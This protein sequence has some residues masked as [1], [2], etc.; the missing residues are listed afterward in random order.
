MGP[1]AAGAAATPRP[2]PGGSAHFSLE[3]A[4][5]G[6]PPVHTA[7]ASPPTSPPPRPPQQHPRAGRPVRARHWPK[8]APPTA[9]GLRAAPR[10]GGV[11]AAA[12]VARRARRGAPA[13]SSS[14]RPRLGVMA[15]HVGGG[16][17]QR[18]RS[19][20][21][22]GWVA[23]W[24]DRRAAPAGA[25]T[26]KW[27]AHTHRTGGEL[28]EGGSDVVL[29][30][31]PWRNICDADSRPPCRWRRWQRAATSGGPHPAGRPAATTRV[32]SGRGPR[33]DRA[34]DDRGRRRHA[35]PGFSDHTPPNPP[36][37]AAPPR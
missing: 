20:R 31:L 16:G 15:R 10:A 19:R 36:P 35:Q 33:S 34:A 26:V 23:G 22:G 2:P 28:G 14:K 8:N 1:A 29:W 37:P 17:L 30:P 12:V 5:V 4:C 7:A 6:A 27:L 25:T 13:S 9:G 18:R 32:P 21:R 11:A 24:C 3:R